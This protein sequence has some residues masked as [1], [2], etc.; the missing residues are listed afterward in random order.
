LPRQA[1]YALKAAKAGL[2]G[3][4]FSKFKIKICSNFEV[5]CRKSP[6]VEEE[7]QRPGGHGVEEG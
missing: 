6:M 2:E 4:V 1:I 3:L 7:M 5:Y